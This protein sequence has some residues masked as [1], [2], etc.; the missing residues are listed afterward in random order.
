MCRV[1]AEYIKAAVIDWLISHHPSVTIGNEVMYGSKR[2]VVDLL[3]IMDNKTIAIE[4]KSS[5][6]NLNRLPDQIAEYSKIFDRVIIISTP[7]H[8][9]GI[10]QLISKGIGLYVIDKSIRRV[11]SPHINI[12]LDKIEMLYS[13]SS[14]FLKKKYPQYKHLNSDEIRFQLSKKNKTVVHQ[15]LISFFQQR[16]S[17]RFRFF[18][19]ERG[20]YTLVDDIPT[21]SSLTRIELF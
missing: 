11:L 7:S 4:I 10:S 20:K 9:S 17:E 2:K 14:D 1:S 21:L 18:M 16:L 3:A 8:I 5:S 15:L 6:D 13:V 19:N 12:N